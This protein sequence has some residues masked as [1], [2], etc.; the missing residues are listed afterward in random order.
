[1][2]VES[3][4]KGA[5]KVASKSFRPKTK[6]GLVGNRNPP[7]ESQII[8]RILASLPF[9][10]LDSIVRF[11]K[12]DSRSADRIWVMAEL[13]KEERILRRS[14]QLIPAVSAPP[15]A[16]AAVTPVQCSNCKR[17]GHTHPDC[18]HP[19]LIGTTNAGGHD[20]NDFVR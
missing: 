17:R 19:G 8:A 14:G 6:R 3:I 11:I 12:N 5:R 15:S 4:Q 10:Q 13:L 20:A 1:M 9:P 7:S 2:E 16:M 18:F